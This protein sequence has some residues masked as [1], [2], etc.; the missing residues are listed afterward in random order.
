[1]KGEIILV[2]LV[3]LVSSIAPSAVSQGLPD[4]YVG[5]VSLS[6]TDIYEGDQVILNVTVGNS[7]A[8]AEDIGVA[9]YVDNRSEAVYEVEISSL[10]EGEKQYVSLYWMAREGSHT[11]FIFADYNSR[12]EEE[13]EDN[14]LISIE[15]EVQKPIYPPFPPSPEKAEWWDSNWHYRVPVTASMM[16]E[17]ENFVY[18]DKMV[19][20]TI[21]FTR[22]MDNISYLQAGSF[23]KRTFYPPSVRVIEYSLDNDTWKVERNV[24]R[25]IILSDDYDAV[26]NANVTVIWTMEGSLSPHERRCYYIYWDTVENGNKRGE[27]ARIKAGFKNG[28]FEDI[29]STQW[30]NTTE[31]SIKWE[32]GYADDPVEKDKCYRI[33]S[34]GMMGNGYIWMPGYAKIYQTINVP[35]GGKTNY[36]LH[37]KIFTIFDLDGVQWHLMLDGESIESGTS[38]GGWIEVTKNVTSYFRNKGSVSVSFKVEI[39]D[40]SISTEQRE[41][42]AYLDSFWIE[43]PDAEIHIFQNNTHGWWSDM[44]DSPQYY[45]AGVDGMDT[46]EHIEVNS[47]AAPREVMAK[48]Y[49]PSS[50]V[51]KT[52]MPL[53]DPSFEEEYYTYVYSSNEK[54]TSSKLQSSVVHTGE[55]AVELRFSNYEGNW[56]YQNREVQ[57]GDVAG[58]RQNITYGISLSEIPELYFWYN[59]EKSSAYVM[60]NYT[61]LT[62]GSK[63]RFYHVYLNDLEGDGEWHRYDIP[64]AV[65]NSWR[66]EGGRVTAVEIRMVAKETGSE[67]TIYID[68]LGYSFTPFNAT[69][70][71][72]WSLDNFYTFYGNAEKGR[73]RLDIIMADGSDYRIERSIAIDVDEAADLD[74]YKIEHPSTIKEGE[75]INFTVYVKNEGKKSVDADTPINITLTVYQEDGEHIRMKKSIA[76]LAVGESKKV[77]FSW[78]ATYGT[79]DGEGKWKVVARINENGAIP[80]SNMNNNW[81]PDFITVEAKP[82]LKITAEDILFSPSHPGINETVNISIIVHNAG[83]ANTTASIRIFEEKGGKFVLV[84][85]KSI[86]EFIE[87]KNWIKV[88]Y[89]WTAE[90]EGVHTIMVEVSCDEEKNTADNTVIKDIKVGGEDD[91]TPPVIDDITIEPAIQS[92]GNSVN[93]SATIYDEDTTIDKAMV[94]ILNGSKESSYCMKRVGTTDLYSFSLS[95]NNVGYYTILIR[96]W[97]TATVPN[98]AESGERQIRIVYEGIETD[99]PVI[100][101]VSIDP[102]DGRQVVK[103]DVNISAYIS[104]ETGI[105]EAIIV[106]GDEGNEESHEMKGGENNIY[107]FKTSY[108]KPGEYY[109]YI[110]AV[111]SSANEN[112]NISSTYYFTIPSDYDMDDVPDIIEREIGS[113]PTNAT[114]TINVSID[115]QIGYLLWVEWVE[116]QGDYVYWDRDANITRDVMMQDK[117]DDG[118]DEI[119]FDS[120]GDGEYDHYYDPATKQLVAY[121]ASGGEIKSQT[122]WIIPPFVLFLLVCIAFLYIR[123]R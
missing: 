110:K 10:G 7:G 73:W 42:V 85:E 89:P 69:D 31:G 14:N 51:V 34:K 117:N 27:F 97:D 40:S 4:I 95:F 99:G 12:I 30:K 121:A 6:S 23:A 64:S 103:G 87:A 37:A 56:N 32:I 92:M 65:L 113:D 68:D 104:D 67:G 106:I 82:D 108:A 1:L 62:I 47:V 8:A 84:T 119:F 49:S 26:K 11:L 115:G 52:S 38:T 93:I 61:L 71:T 33:Y 96:A 91:L 70:R 50:K 63:P 22:L 111:D 112:F 60:L 17:R 44:D 43:T 109:Y 120:N 13:N 123:R 107:Y 48:L 24:G 41:I 18:S 77:D 21:N 36:I 15:V 3:L 66:R 59:V 39:T 94:V 122:I 75:T 57:P 19:Y 28:E 100:K 116:E 2:A 20:C 76:G 101:A 118:I 55:R 98:M 16:G 105:K 45:V 88:F 90:K 54:T 79:D 72:K 81:Y 58:F 53:P 5:D 78:L 102:P 9:L 46:I 25:E 35:D 29:Y 86:E 114:G 80:E 83:H 74:V